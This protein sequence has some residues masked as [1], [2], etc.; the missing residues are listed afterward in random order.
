M[1]ACRVMLLRVRSSGAFSPLLQKGQSLCCGLWPKSTSLYGDRM[2]MFLISVLL[3]SPL[4]AFANPVLE[5]GRD[6]DA[7]HRACLTAIADDPETAYE[8]AMTWVGRGG[9]YRAQHCEAMALFTLG[10]E[11]EAG[12]RLDKIVAAFPAQT[13]PDLDR[14][15]VN[16]ATEAAQAW[17]QAEYPDR[18]YAS[19]TRALEIEPH[20]VEARITRARI[21]FALDRFDDAETDLTS[22]LSYHPDHP[23]ILRY[24]ADARLRQD[25]LDEALADAE[26]SLSIT[27]SVDTALIRGHI[28]EAL[29]K[30]RAHTHTGTPQ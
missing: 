1:S 12:F 17:L 26:L 18:A 29:A 13:D 4:T 24:R 16:Y 8:T 11:K 6:Y 25:K 10:H 5:A 2:R 27:P 20:H 7:R 21:Y 14:L 15:K 9:G 19:A 22:A 3:L 23:E 28:R 30:S